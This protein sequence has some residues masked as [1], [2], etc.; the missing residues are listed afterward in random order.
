MTAVIQMKVKT[1][2]DVFDIDGTLYRTPIYRADWWIKND[3]QAYNKIKYDWWTSRLS[4]GDPYIPCPAPTDMH[5]EHIVQRARESEADPNSHFVI[6]TG[7]VE[8]LRDL[9]ERN[10][11]EGMGLAPDRIFLKEYGRTAQ[12][13]EAK[14]LELIEDLGITEVEM[15]E[16]QHKYVVRYGQ[17]LENH[18]QIETYKVHHVDEHSD[19]HLDLELEKEVVRRILHEKATRHH[20]RHHKR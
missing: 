2:L 7:R 20:L 9:V 1:K 11:L 8:S 16:D 5:I 15:W 14:L 3:P 17:F 10:I 18:P 19:W 12:Y 13:K 4:L 6:M